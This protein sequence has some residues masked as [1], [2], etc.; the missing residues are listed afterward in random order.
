MCSSILRNKLKFKAKQSVSVVTKLQWFPSLSFRYFFSS[1][2]AFLSSRAWIIIAAYQKLFA[3]IFTGGGKYIHI[4]ASRPAKQHQFAELLSPFIW[5]PKCL[6]FFY[7]MYGLHMGRL[8]VFVRA[9]GQPQSYLTWQRTGNQG[10]Q[11]RKAVVDIPNVDEFQV[12]FN[13]SIP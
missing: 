1:P 5:G 3:H 2:V 7:H 12:G 13:L 8:E 4:E 10:N 11:W 6:H 9:A